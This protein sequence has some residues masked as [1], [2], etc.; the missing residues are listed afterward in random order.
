MI[1][2]NIS[3]PIATPIA[4]TSS[5]NPGDYGNTSENWDFSNPNT[6]AETS[7]LLTVTGLVG[8][9]TL[10][11]DASSNKPI[12]GTRTLNGKNVLDFQGAQFLKNT[13]LNV[14]QDNTVV[15]VGG[16]DTNSGTQ[17][18]FSGTNGLS[19][20][21]SLI[22]GLRFSW[23]AGTSRLTSGADLNPHIYA[24]RWN[25]ASSVLYRD[26]VGLSIQDPGSNPLTGL[27]IGAR[28]TT[29]THFLDGQIGQILVYSGAVDIA[30]LTT[31]LRGKWGL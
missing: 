29:T 6:I 31:A 21:L 7:E 28:Y 25:E 8:G 24:V 27:V 23:F 15:V 16:W 5:F 22:S 3:Q 14:P 9:A 18:M 19:Q 17:K 4:H 20:S 10:I 30:G 13:T 2:T 1:A 11:N 12:N 26:G